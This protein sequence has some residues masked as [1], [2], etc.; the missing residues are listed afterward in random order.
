M[1]FLVKVSMPVEAGN[2]A[3]KEGALGKTIQ[4][5]LA[6][7]KPEAAYFTA[8]NGLRTGILILQ[9]DDASKIPAIAEPWF[10]A[11]NANV[12]IHP[13]MLPQDLEKAGNSIASSAKTY[14][15]E[16]VSV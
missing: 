6:E 11:F 16:C 4:M 14:A 12:E 3:V 2:K 1:R 5:I 10:L 13:V 15:R 8:L 7:Q 9:I